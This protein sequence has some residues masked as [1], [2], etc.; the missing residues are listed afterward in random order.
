MLIE[1]GNIVDSRHAY[2]QPVRTTGLLDVRVGRCS[3]SEGR[4][5]GS[6]C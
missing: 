3:I 6:G 4:R 1:S 5:D 2:G